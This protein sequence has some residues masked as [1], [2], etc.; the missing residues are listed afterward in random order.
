MKREKSQTSQVLTD[1]SVVDH[2]TTLVAVHV[3]IFC[4]VSGAKKFSVKSEKIVELI[5]HE[6][7]SINLAKLSE[8]IC[9]K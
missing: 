9:V 2:L 1:S 3:K 7:P 4:I 6:I 5:L 8:S